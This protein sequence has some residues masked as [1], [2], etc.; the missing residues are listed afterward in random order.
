MTMQSGVAP[1]ELPVLP[2]L[3]GRAMAVLWSPAP[4]VAD[5]LSIV[6]GDPALTASVLRAANSSFA[7][8]TGPILDAPAAIERLGV[9]ATQQLMTAAFTRAEFEH[10]TRSDLHFDD[11]WSWQLAVALLAELFSL[12]DRRPAEETAAAF[13]AGL[14]HQVGRLSLVARNPERYRDV[15]TLVN[16]GVDPLEAEWQLLNDDAVHITS[17]VGMHWGFFEP[18]AS[19][20]GNL[21]NPE[22][23]DLAA[24]LHE[25]STVAAQLGFS[26]GFAVAVAAPTPLPP[27]HP[28]HAALA[29]IGGLDGLIREIDWFH[30]ATGARTPLGAR[31]P[32][33]GADAPDRLAG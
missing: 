22:P 3:K 2:G 30:H 28:R 26:E 5:L 1:P 21:A 9:D 16:T 12:H 17:Q 29:S 31:P 18:L 27:A 20:L 7:P 32:S 24:T 10:L 11:L 33:A 15:V 8:P 19:T 4:S 25:A 23:I 6:E 14:L 13:T